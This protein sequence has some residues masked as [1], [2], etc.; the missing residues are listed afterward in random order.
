MTPR[1]LTA[2]ERAEIGA[3]CARYTV[4]PEYR[5]LLAAEAHWHERAERYAA[6]LR[7]IQEGKGKFS[8]DPLTHASNTIDDMK[9]LAR[10]ALAEPE[11]P[12]G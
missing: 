12:K 11:E 1:P 10:A 2:E 9:A 6:A 3:L 5:R 8:R 7:E 4:A